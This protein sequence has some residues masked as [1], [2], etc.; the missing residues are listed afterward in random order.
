MRSPRSSGY[1]TRWV[2]IS[3]RGRAWEPGWRSM[4]GPRRERGITLTIGIIGTG[5][6]ADSPERGAKTDKPIVA[7]AQTP[8]NAPS[9]STASSG[10]PSPRAADATIGA[11]A[12][13]HGTTRL[14][15]FADDWGRHPSSCQHLVRQLLRRYPVLWVNTIGTRRPRLCREDLSKAAVKLRAWLAVASSGRDVR[16]TDAPAAH[17]PRVVSPWMYPG[18]RRPWQRRLNAWAIARGVEHAL[19]PRQPGERRVV[20]TTLPITAD[21]VGRL[22]ADRWLYY[23]VDDFS[24]WPGLDGDV[25]DAMERRLVKRVDRV[26]AV[27]QTL[28][29]RIAGMGRDAELLTHGL[30]LR[31]WH[32]LA[33]AE[34]TR[35][36]PLPPWWSDLR[37]PVL[38]FW[39]VVDRRLDTSWCRALAERCGTLALVGPRQTPDPRLTSHERIVMPG[40]VPYESLPALAAAADVLVMPYADLPVTRAIQPLKLKEYLATGKPVVARRLP[41]T[42]PWADAADLV[43]TLDD[44]VAVTRQRI[45]RDT[46][47]Q[48]LTARQRLREETWRH[49]ADAFERLLTAA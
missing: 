34:P 15:V 25:M 32:W 4:G 13:R 3:T 27:S 23:C 18:F 22:D 11:A 26:V 42:E 7:T 46:P 9:R 39:G 19:G 37:R 8:V 29:S 38:L 17:A 30:D 21:L 6:C 14:I 40:A 5:L 1:G 47:A 20:V 45:E 43:A 41:A 36:G 10:G 2:S 35:F 44:A 31:H 49:K 12:G 16:A 24:A 48:Q 33:G 28:R